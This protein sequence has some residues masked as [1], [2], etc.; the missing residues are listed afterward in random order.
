MG[1]VTDVAGDPTLRGRGVLFTVQLG[2][3]LG[4]PQ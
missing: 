2:S 4:L 1:A 3:V